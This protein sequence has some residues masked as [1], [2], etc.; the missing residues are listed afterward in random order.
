MF[1]YILES[2][3]VPIENLK[4]GRVSYKGMN[5]EIETIMLE[6]TTREENLRQVELEV[7]DQEMA[8]RYSNLVGT[9]N[10]KFNK[11]RDKEGKRVGSKGTN[12]SNNPQIMA[13]AASFLAQ[14]RKE[15]EQNL[16]KKANFQK[17][18]EDE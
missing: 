3:Y 13:Q 7:T 18:S 5:P 6:D 9:I 15:T 14:V 17:P 1:R 16:A 12:A 11:K 4:F 2:S 8:E 10:N